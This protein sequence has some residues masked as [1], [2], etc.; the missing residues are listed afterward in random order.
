[1]PVKKKQSSTITLPML[2]CQANISQ[3][4][5]ILRFM[6]ICTFTCTLIEVEIIQ[7]N[8]I[9]KMHVYRSKVKIMFLP[10]S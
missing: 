1:M 3:Y 6:T 9:H 4:L 8:F 5:G 10:K 7:Q 2:S